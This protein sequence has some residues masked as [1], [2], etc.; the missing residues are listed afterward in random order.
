V[1]TAEAIATLIEQVRQLTEEIRK[2]ASTTVQQVV[3]DE[4]CRSR[5]REIEELTRRVM[6]VE[7]RPVRM[8][9]IAVGAVGLLLAAGSLV[10]AMVR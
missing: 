1:S 8:W 5:A 4:R 7:T 6:A 10:V 3:C 2:L 9:P